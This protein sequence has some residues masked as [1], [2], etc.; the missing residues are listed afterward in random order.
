MI[1]EVI[2]DI[3]LSKAEAVAHGVAPKP[4]F[5]QRVGLALREQRPGM[6]RD[7]RHYCQVSHPK[8]GELWSWDGAGGVRIV[9]L[10]TQEP[11][12]SH[13]ANQGQARVEHVNHCLK[14]LHQTVD[15]GKI[16][17]VALQKLATGVKELDWE[18]VKPF[19]EKH[20]GDLWIPVYV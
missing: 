6:V 19:L 15:S 12:P 7:F 5:W 20:L 10:M 1:Y 2:G 13:G 18:A 14:A 9:N 3:L 4:Q 17:S 16:A 8:R 11:A